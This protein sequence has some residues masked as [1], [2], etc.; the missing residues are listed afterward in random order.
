MAQGFSMLPEALQTK[1]QSPSV[2]LPI[3]LK[4]TDA[5]AQL[6]DQIEKGTREREG[7][8]MIN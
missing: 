3:L 1:S 2:R 7:G 4:C 6:V 8:R 5:A